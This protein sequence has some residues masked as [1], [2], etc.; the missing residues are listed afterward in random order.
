MDLS[1]VLVVAGLIVMVIGAVLIIR[2]TPAPSPP[3]GGGTP[4]A[5][6]DI[7]EWIKQVKEL[8]EVFEKHV[9]TGLFVLILGFV[10]VL[11][12]VWLDV[13]DT[14]QTVQEAALSFTRLL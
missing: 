8:L 14:N 12:G 9:R 3:G 6:P 1:D 5:L 4:E 10:L 13:R 7:G 11:L 2:P